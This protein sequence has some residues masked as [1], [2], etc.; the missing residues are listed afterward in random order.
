MSV[1]PGPVV[2]EGDVFGNV[3]DDYT[4]ERALRVTLQAWI[5][6]HLAHQERRWQREPGK[7]ARPQSWPERIGQFDMK[8]HEH[9]PAVFVIY[10]GTVPNA[11]ERLRNGQYRQAFAFDVIVV[12][13]GSDERDCRQAASM[14][15]AAAKSAV[16]QNRRLDGTAETTV[17]TG[18]DTYTVGRVLGA[19]Q[20]GTD[21]AVCG[22]TFHVYVR[23][24]VSDRAGPAS[25]P[26]DP[27]VPDPLPPW[28]ETAEFIVEADLESNE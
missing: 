22:T 7:L 19:D 18:P 9:L 10:K 11:T 20:L 1:E 3:I 26:T 15:L 27:H 12:I 4:V 28:P 14:Y 17:L 23:N 5:D 6:S 21:R 16:V 25:P 2:P 8:L 13:A 24:T